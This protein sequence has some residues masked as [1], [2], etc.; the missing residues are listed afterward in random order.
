MSMR[1]SFQE[2]MGRHRPKDYINTWEKIRAGQG[3]GIRLEMQA[4]K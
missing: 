4:I 1:T 3:E 2:S